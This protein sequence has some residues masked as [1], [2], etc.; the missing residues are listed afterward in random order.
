MPQVGHMRLT[1]ISDVQK[2][3]VGGILL[4]PLIKERNPT[5]AVKTTD[6]LH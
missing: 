4:V 5:Q 1:F 2:D 3:F 6:I